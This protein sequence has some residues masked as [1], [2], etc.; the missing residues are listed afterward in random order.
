MAAANKATLDRINRVA[1]G[2][3][4]PD[5]ETRSLWAATWSAR[6]AAMLEAPVKKNAPGRLWRL[7][8]FQDD[9]YLVVTLVQNI[10]P[11]PG[12]PGQQAPKVVTF[13]TR[14][15]HRSN[16][17]G[18]TVSQQ[19][20]GEYSCDDIVAFLRLDRVDPDSGAAW[21]DETKY[22]DIIV[23]KD[24]IGHLAKRVH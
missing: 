9:D 5:T 4:G 23:V 20:F 15:Y 6:I 7:R 21:R 2:E 12:V 14:P 19:L 1:R 16:A 17:A 18:S 8:F 22:S 11:P 10:T 24:V 3:T 13:L